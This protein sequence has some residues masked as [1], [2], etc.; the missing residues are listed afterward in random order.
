MTRKKEAVCPNCGQ[1]NYKPPTYEQ[2]PK[3]DS[4]CIS[5]EAVLRE[6][7]K[8]LCGVPFNEKGIDEVIKELP[9]VTPSRPKGKWIV[10]REEYEFMGGI[11]NEPRGCKCSNCNKVVRFKSVFCPNCGADMRESEDK[12]EKM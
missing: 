4:D 5:R 10:L 9:P 8:Y 12:N 2:A 7:D 1:W 6:L 11:V 3:I